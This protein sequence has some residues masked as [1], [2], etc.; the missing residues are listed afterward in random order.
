MRRQTKRQILQRSA[1]KS[2]SRRDGGKPKCVIHT[3]EEIEGIRQAA[4][5]TA[6]ILETILAGIRPGVTLNDLDLLAGVIMRDHG[7]DSA[8]KGYLG[9]PGEISN[10]VNDE[11]VHGV[12]CRDR[13]IQLGDIVSVDCG[14][15]C[16]G[17]I[18]DTAKTVSVGPAVGQIAN[19]MSVTEKSLMAGIDVARDGNTVWDIGVAIENV[20]SASGYK[21][22]RDFVG[23]G[24]G[25]KLHEAP[26]VPNYPTSKSREPLHAGM[27]LA[28]EPMVNV[29]DHRVKID[30]DGWTVRTI[31]GSWSAHFEHMILITESK[32]EILTWPKSVSN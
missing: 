7:V 16:G 10:S 25:V 13:I 9:K 32:P 17:Y 8:F 26:E 31:D 18:G 22:V 19:L 14:T 30:D 3:A 20:V 24:C 29:G 12:S 1:K 2:R 23:H 6:G 11:V 27:V 4:A 15:R 5:T 21:V 28:L